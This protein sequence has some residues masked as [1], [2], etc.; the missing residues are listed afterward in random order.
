[1]GFPRDVIC[2]NSLMDYDDLIYNS[3]LPVEVMQDERFESE[4]PFSNACKIILRK[5]E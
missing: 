5:R 1:M 3:G 4:N 2:W